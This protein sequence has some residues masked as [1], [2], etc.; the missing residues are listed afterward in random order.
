MTEALNP[1]KIAQRQLDKAAERLGLDQATHEFL[2]WPMREFS[3]TLP[4]KMD[5]G[6]TR[7]FHG[8]RVQYNTA[9]GPAKGGLRWHPDETLD[10]VR[11]LAAWMTWKTSVVDI[12]LGGGK[13]GIV[14]NP[15]EL[16]ETEKERL[17]RAYI[18]AIASALGVTKD[19][20][21]P[22]VYTTPQI[23]AWMMDE[24][25]T[26]MREH[27]PGVIT[28][29]PVSIGGSKGRNDA[30]ARGGIYV[31]REA[32]KTYGIDLNGQTMAVQGFGNA[33]QFAAL[34][35]EE[36]LGLKLVAA[37]DSKGGV[38]NPKGIDAKALVDYKL[39][40]GTLQGFP[41][42]EPISNEDLLE[43][44]VMVLFPSALENVIT[45][46]NASRIR[47][48]MICELAN[49]PTTPEADE[50]LFEKGV[51][52][53]PD[54]LANAGGVTVSYFEQVQNTYNFYWELKEVHWR[55]DE[56]MTRAFRSVYEM[57]S[58]E[59]IH[60]REAAYLVSVARVAEACKLR[61]WV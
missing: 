39:Q 52:V 40:N 11:A 42:A 17:A 50:I 14:C 43:L 12:P 45:E 16:S 29:K 35:G 8:F 27:H 1:F 51:I 58:R 28:G 47:A 7:V 21:A 36:L 20:P 30:T 26:I 41:G 54:F 33:G 61:G 24:Y 5:D 18:R 3:F 25:E 60:L 49:G 31:T 22:D 56:K 48:R 6:S 15:K 19:V 57:G 53:L 10:T 44:D 9:R 4:V 59:K 46:A 2:R 13:G 38:Y 32:A 37:S 34:L 23:M 55:L